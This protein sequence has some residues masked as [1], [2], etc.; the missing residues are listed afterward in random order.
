MKLFSSLCSALGHACQTHTLFDT[1]VSLQYWSSVV[2]SACWAGVSKGNCLLP[3]WRPTKHGW[4]KQAWLFAASHHMPSFLLLLPGP[5]RSPGCLP[6]AISGICC[7]AS[8][9]QWCMETVVEGSSVTYSTT[10]RKTGE[11]VFA[12]S[13]CFPWGWS[14]KEDSRAAEAAWRG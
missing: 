3:G 2:R 1:C 8:A 6:W 7:R 12:A 10:F 14:C 9:Q 4:G 11:P 13:H 5:G